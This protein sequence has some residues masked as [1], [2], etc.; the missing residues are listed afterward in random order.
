MLWCNIECLQE[1]HCIGYVL[2][3]DIASYKLWRP[4][5]M[6][7]FYIYK[8]ILERCLLTCQD[9]KFPL[10]NH[11][12]WFYV[13]WLWTAWEYFCCLQELLNCLHVILQ[14][15]WTSPGFV[16]SRYMMYHISLNKHHTLNSS[17]T[18]HRL[19]LLVVILMR[20]LGWRLLNTL[21]ITRVEH[22]SPLLGS[23]SVCA[24]T[25]LLNAVVKE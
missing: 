13:P 25:V 6:W 18:T 1:L 23:T 14:G 22:C 19:T 10:H 17:R 20:R 9:N 16:M 21:K 15:K 7:L 24:S 5:I 4:F 11:S 12:T 8:H 2:I 3:S